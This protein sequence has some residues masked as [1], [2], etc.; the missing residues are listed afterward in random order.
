M[1]G[2]DFEENKILTIFKEIESEIVRSSILKTGKRIDGRDTK[3]VRPIVSEVGVLPRP[4][5][6]H[7]LLEVKHKH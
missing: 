7:C 4:M 6:Q 3:T 1:C 2:E 5:G